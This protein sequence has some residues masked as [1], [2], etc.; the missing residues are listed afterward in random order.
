[1]PLRPA[2][3]AIT[4]MTASYSLNPEPVTEIPAGRVALL[5]MDDTFATH[6]DVPPIMTHRIHA[7]FGP[8][9]PEQ[10]EFAQQFPTEATQIAGP[11]TVSSLEPVVIGPPLAGSG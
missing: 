3:P 4:L 7:T 2:V 6:D 8:V 11:V 1:M 5:L 10:A 9:I